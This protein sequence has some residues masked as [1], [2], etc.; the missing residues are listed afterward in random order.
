MRINKE[1]LKLKPKPPTTKKKT[2]Q[3]CPRDPPNLPDQG[4]S[5]FTS[6][7]PAPARKS[8]ERSFKWD[9]A[10]P[11]G[12]SGCFSLSNQDGYQDRNDKKF[13]ISN[14]YQG[15][16]KTEGFQV[17]F[18]MPKIVLQT[19]SNLSCQKYFCKHILIISN[20]SKRINYLRRSYMREHGML[21]ATKHDLTFLVISRDFPMPGQNLVQVM[22]EFMA[23]Q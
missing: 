19:Y 20:L 7:A 8:R 16:N 3:K 5:R 11:W 21:A 17:G 1:P 18:L 4:T 13:G 9:L 2:S 6:A 10:W 23:F 12:K 15:K 22:H 14:I